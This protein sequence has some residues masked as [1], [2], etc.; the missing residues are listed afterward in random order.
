MSIYLLG[1]ECYVR[2]NL[3]ICSYKLINHHLPVLLS[4]REVTQT[5]K[6][7]MSLRYGSN[8]KSTQLINI[9]LRCLITFDLSSHK[10]ETLFLIDVEKSHFYS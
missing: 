1:H 9:N 10:F 4:F 2:I 5:L 3:P 8:G 7:S 6:R